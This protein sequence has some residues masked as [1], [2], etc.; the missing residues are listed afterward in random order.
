MRCWPWRRAGLGLRQALQRPEI[1]LVWDRLMLR[2]P[3]IGG[4]AREILAARLSR[5]LGMLLING[6]A[7]LPALGIVEEVLGNKAAQKA[8]PTPAESAKTG[9]GISRALGTAAIFPTRLVHL[10]RLGEET[11]QLGPLSLR[12]ADCSRSAPA[13]L[14]SA[15]WRC[16]CRPSPFSWVLRWRASSPRCCWPCSA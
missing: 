2:L 5:T 9:Q 4:I 16:W 8:V 3:L 7:L 1:R 10:L 14:C 11:A 6:V 15:W 12:A 13:S